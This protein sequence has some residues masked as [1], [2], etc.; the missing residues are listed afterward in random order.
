MLTTKA[1]IDTRIEVPPYDEYNREMVHNVHP[2]DWVNPEP[3]PRY[4]FVVIGAGTAGLVA[5]AGTAVLG[6]KV[7]LIE[8]HLMGGDCLVTG[9]VP[10]KAVIRSSRVYADI[11]DANKFGAVVPTGAEMDF[12]AVMERMRSIRA[13]ISRHDSAKQFRELGAD[14]FLGEARFSGPDTVEVA[15]KTLRFKKAVIATGARPVVPP[16]EG[17]GETEYLTNENVFNLTERPDRLLVIGGGPLG[18]ELAQSFRRLGSEVTIVEMG[19]QFLPR[20]DRDAAD[21]L[22]RAFSLD[23][24]NIRLNTK[25]KSVSTFADEKRIVL[26]FDGKEEIIAVDQI[27][28]G[29]GRAPNVEGLNLEAVGVE[30]DKNGVKVNDYL[31]TTNSHIYA[32]GDICLPYKFTHTA[33]AAARIVIQNGLFLGRKRF[34]TL[35]IPWCTYTDPEIAHVGLYKRDAE[36]RGI[37]VDTIII[38]MSQ[39]DRALADGED[40]GFLKVHV[41]RG[42]DKIVGA[43]IVARHAGEMIS[44]ITM[45]IVGGIGLKKIAAI[46]HPYPTQAEAIKRAADEY[47]RTRLTPFLK[48]VLSYWLAWTR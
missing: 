5:A 18:C 7:A 24:I 46:I 19:Q 44:E 14:I 31:Q 29:A 33:D 38:P 32:A 20:E 37:P 40:E 2:P 35:S 8:R 17:L 21:I 3:A 15:G 1:D 11:R 13:R 25:V 43:T 12:P 36:K 47:N 10:S 48:K 42:S 16:I 41:K 23:G 34:S 4:N 9:C 6:G 30:Y 26:E 28:V 39:V 22:A 45:A 27:L